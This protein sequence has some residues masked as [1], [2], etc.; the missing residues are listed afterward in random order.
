MNNQERIFEIINESRYGFLMEVN[1]YKASIDLSQQFRPRL[2][3]S[4]VKEVFEQLFNEQ[5][6]FSKATQI[7]NGDE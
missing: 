4:Q 1:S 2:T 5:I 7:L 3:V 6:S